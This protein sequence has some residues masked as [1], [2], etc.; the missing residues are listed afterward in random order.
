M[1]DQSIHHRAAITIV[2]QSGPSQPCR[3]S[4]PA[5]ADD[6]VYSVPPGWARWG[7]FMLSLRFARL[8]FRKANGIMTM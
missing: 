3:A 7:G 1:F 6:E 5:G 4:P 8:F 2:D